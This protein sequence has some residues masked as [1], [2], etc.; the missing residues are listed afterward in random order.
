[1]T[2]PSDFENL[3]G[4]FTPHLNNISEPVASDYIV[5]LYQYDNN[6][7]KNASQYVQSISSFNNDNNEAKEVSNIYYKLCDQI[8]ESSEK[9]KDD[10]EIIKH[11]NIIL[12]FQKSML[13]FITKINEQKDKTFELEKESKSSYEKIKNDIGKLQDFSAFM[14]TIDTKYSD[15]VFN[16]INKSILDVSKKISVDNNHEEIKKSFLKQNYILNLYLDSIKNMN[17]LN[18]G[19]TCSICFKRSVDTFMEP[20]GHTGCSECIQTLIQRSGGEFNCNCFYCRKSIIKF[21]KLYF[22]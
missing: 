20:C 6:V 18:T 9:I 7:N 16:D 11:K 22:T 21:H 17:S 13:D 15:V 5:N 2:E 3:T 1:M 14:N 8:D 4:P 19:N 12:N 10:D